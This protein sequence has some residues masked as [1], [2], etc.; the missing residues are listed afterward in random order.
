[1]WNRR[2]EG[3]RAMVANLMSEK[4]RELIAQ[5]AKFYDQLAAEAERDRSHEEKVPPKRDESSSSGRSE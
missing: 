1:M 3:A 5:I 4:S 2:A